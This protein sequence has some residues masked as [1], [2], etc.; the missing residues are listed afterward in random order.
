MENQELK[1]KIYDAI[2]GVVGCEEAEK[3]STMAVA[4]MTELKVRDVRFTYL[5]KDGTTREAF[6]TTRPEALPQ[7]DVDG[8]GGEKKERTPNYAMLPYF[9]LEK[10]A[11]RGCKIE[12][13]ISFDDGSES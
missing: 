5:K 2:V 10:V 4:L 6:G 11:W 12:N 9:D 13:L 1:T 3:K 7:T 8:G